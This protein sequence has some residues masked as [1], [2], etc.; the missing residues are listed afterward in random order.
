MKLLLLPFVLLLGGPLGA[1]PEKSPLA[2]GIELSNQGKWEEAI[3]LLEQAAKAAPDSYQAA[4]ALGSARLSAKQYVMAK[5]E[6][7]RAAKLEPGSASTHY[8]LALL[9]EKLKEHRKAVAAWR[10]FLSHKLDVDSRQVAEKHLA[11]ELEH[12]KKDQGKTP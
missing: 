2:Q 9:Y 3:P 11:H 8:V 4:L 12:L 7:E 10:I 1:Q 6:L 5:G